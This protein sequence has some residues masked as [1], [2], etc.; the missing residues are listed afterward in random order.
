MR[1]AEPQ[2]DKEMLTT[3]IF[4]IPMLTTCLL[5]CNI[6]LVIFSS[7]FWISALVGCL[8]ESDQE[9]AFAHYNVWLGLASCV[10]FMYGQYLCFC[11]K[12]YIMAGVMGMAAISYF[13]LEIRVLRSEKR[14]RATSSS[15]ETPMLPK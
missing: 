3:T 11:T 2:L 9:A 7:F 10:T 12:A 5:K 14:H 13:T 1:R 4:N 8:F 6:L 15:S